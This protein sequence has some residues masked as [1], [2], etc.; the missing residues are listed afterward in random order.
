[1]KKSVVIIEDDSDIL[2]VLSYCLKGAGYHVEAANDGEEGVNLVKELSP[3]LVILD[4]NLP[5]LSGIEISRYLKSVPATAR[6]P[7]MMI[8]V[9]AQQSNKLCAF[10]NGVSDYLTKP[11]DPQEVVLRANALTSHSDAR[12]ESSIIAF[13]N[14]EI[15]LPAHQVKVSGKNIKLRPKEFKLLWLLLSHQGS[16][17]S[18]KN[19]KS[20]LWDDPLDSTD[21]AVQCYIARLREKLGPKIGPLIQNVH[22]QGYVIA[23]GEMSRN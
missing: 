10:Q 3:D 14:I 4:W 17:V 16:V 21:G 15:N 23:P 22:R 5:G 11:F 8:T 13:K 6:I 9:Y 20:S 12:T 2:K 19:I 1:M 7:V 18:L